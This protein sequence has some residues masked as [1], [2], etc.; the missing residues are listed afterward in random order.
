MPDAHLTDEQVEQFDRDGF[1]IL[2]G[3]FDRS[4]VVRMAEEADRILELV[5]N[6][7]LAQ[8]RPDSRLDTQATDGRF[9]V[10]KV[11]PVNDL[12]EYLTA[13]SNDD[14]L[15][16]PMSRI[17]GC[18]PLLMEEKLNYKQQLHRPLDAAAL[19][20]RVGDDRFFIHTDWGYYRQQGYPK[21]TLSSA[22]SIDACTPD[23]GPIRVFPGTHKREYPLADPASPGSGVLREEP[24]RDAERVPVLC[25]PGS[26]MVFHAML[27][28]DSCPNLTGRPRRIM[29]YSHYPET[30]RA[31]PDQ[32]NG[33]NRRRAQAFEA[34]YLKM[35]RE[36]RCR[37]Q[38]I[39]KA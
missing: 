1:L 8:G 29:I 13:V 39:A 24:F 30:H 35:V 17:L 4:E 5:I 20:P 22:I 23:N 21:N 9:C 27:V 26:V 11:Q 10:R 31:D 15:I 25:A 36:G 34:E 18:R 14:R 16:G 3:L 28:H 38:F 7:S 33:P 37:P 19:Q 2:E 32:R 12:S 6:A